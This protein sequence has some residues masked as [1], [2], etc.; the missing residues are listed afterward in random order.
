MLDVNFFDELRIGTTF[1][2]VVPVPDGARGQT[3][4]GTTHHVAWRAPDDETEED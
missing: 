3:A 4:V 1:A 2:D